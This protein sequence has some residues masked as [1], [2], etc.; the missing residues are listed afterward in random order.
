VRPADGARDVRYAFAHPSP[1]ELVDLYGG[2][3]WGELT[4]EV[5]ARALAGSWAVC[6]AR[7]ADGALVGVGRLLGDGALHAFV[8][9]LVVHAEHRGGGVGGEILDQLVAWSREHG[10]HDVQLF[11]ARGRAPFYE[12][13]GF[14]PRPTDAPG[15]DLA[16]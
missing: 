5:A 10:V 7:T 11:A 1:A 8:T 15:M 16:R 14:R 2:T 13:H 6:T 4:P 9:E 12:R 3:G